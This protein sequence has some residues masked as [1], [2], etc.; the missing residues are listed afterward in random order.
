MIEVR[1]LSKSYGSR[2]AVSD[3]SFDVARGEI[4][5]FL[6]PNGAGKSTTMRILAGCLAAS[7]GTARVAGFDVFEDSLSARRALGYLPEQVPLYPEMRVEEYLRFAASL[8]Q[9]D[10]AELEKRLGSVLGRCGLLERRDHLIGRL[11]RGYR[12]R[13][14]LAQAILPNPPV[15]ILDEP[16]VGLDP[17]QIIEVRELIRDLAGDHTVLLSTHILP[18]VSMLCSRVVIIDHGRVVAEDTPSNLSRTVR[19]GE[20][21]QV[22]VEGPLPEIAARLR[23]LPAVVDVQ[24][25]AHSGTGAGTL[26]VQVSAPDELSARLARRAIA[27]AIVQGGWGLTELTTEKLSL[28]DVFVRLVTEEA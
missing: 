25:G 19:G 23:S 6:G 7:S 12:Q 13:V 20:R 22:E 28:E 18:E 2:P 4:L 27:E 3:V 26:T 21:V 24:E 16:T 14:G 5:G 9:M 11:S 15:I 10:S 1:H 8:R 17:K